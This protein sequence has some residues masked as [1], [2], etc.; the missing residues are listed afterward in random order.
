M[1]LT[2][3]YLID[4]MKRVEARNPNDKQFLIT[5]RSVLESIEPVVEARPELIEKGGIYKELYQLYAAM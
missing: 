3:A 2:N 5:V 4:L 1:A